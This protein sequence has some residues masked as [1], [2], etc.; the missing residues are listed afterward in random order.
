MPF[1]DIVQISRCKKVNKIESLHSPWVYTRK[2]LVLFHLHNC[3]YC[4]I[5]LHSTTFGNLNFESGLLH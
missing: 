5:W 1:N 3:D 2:N 4:L